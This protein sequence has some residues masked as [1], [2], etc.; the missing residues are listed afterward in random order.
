M[1]VVCDHTHAHNCFASDNG[2]DAMYVENV[3]PQKCK[4][5]Q[6]D[7]T[8]ACSGLHSASNVQNVRLKSANSLKRMLCQHAADCTQPQKCKIFASKVRKPQKCKFQ[9]QT[10][11]TVVK[12]QVCM[13]G[14]HPSHGV[15]QLTK[16]YHAFACRKVVG[17]FAYR[18]V[19]GVFAC[20]W[21]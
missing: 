13:K 2:G 8:S 10:C 6:K 21:V 11:K 7:A 15:H 17:V 4:P 3:S 1:G 16:T 12:V 18:K 14:A 9:P 20:K 5:P 19:V